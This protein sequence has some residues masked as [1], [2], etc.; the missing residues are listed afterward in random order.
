MLLAPLVGCER[1]ESVE[2]RIREQ[3]IGAATAPHADLPPDMV[4][5]SANSQRS[6][7]IEVEPAVK[8]KVRETLPTVGWLIPKVGYEIV[9][10]APTAGFI[11]PAGAAEEF[12]IGT[13]VESDAVLGTLEVF[14]S[15]Q[16]Q[17]QLAT[18]KEEADT[19]M[20]QA[21]VT[22]ELAQG[23][24]ERLKSARDSAAGTRLLDL[25]EILRKARVAYEEGRDRLPYLPEEPYNG[26]VKL[27]PI[28]VAAP[29]SGRILQVHAS[30]RQFVTAGDPLWTVANW[31]TLWLR[32]PVFQTDLSRV[33]A[34]EPD[35]TI[36]GAH[37]A[38]RRSASI[39]PRPRTPASAP[40]T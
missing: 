32:V 4:R 8:R 1:F 15:P 19:I 7:G 30:P 20:N 24:L 40:S 10:K 23:Q 34:Y 2:E 37:Q 17:A 25:E 5:N 22:I 28:H 21:L 6:I 31:S 29:I 12:A 14:L 11:R 9:V 33:A 26:A 35:L 38:L 39:C 36:L 18:A 3:A 27:R 16:E 13:M